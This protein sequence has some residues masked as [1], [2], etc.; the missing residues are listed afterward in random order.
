MAPCP[1]PA[2]AHAVAP[3][4]V[5]A[6]VNGGVDTNGSQFYITTHASPHLDGYSVAFGRVTKGMDVIEKV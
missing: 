3:S 6:S 5:C 1:A 4:F 2:H